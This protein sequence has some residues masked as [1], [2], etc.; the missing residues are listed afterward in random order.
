MMLNG[1]VAYHCNHHGVGYKAPGRV[2]PSKPIERVS[3][4]RWYEPRFVVLGSL[5]VMNRFNMRYYLLAIIK[6]L[7]LKCDPSVW[8]NY[9][10]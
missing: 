7:I 6:S 1:L 4:K 3:V 8:L 9:E 5:A 2:S 10:V